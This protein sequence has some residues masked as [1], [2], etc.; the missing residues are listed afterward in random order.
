MHLLVILL[1]QLLGLLPG[2]KKA[3]Q[4][5]AVPV[6]RSNPRVPDSAARHDGN[7]SQFH[8]GSRMDW[9]TVPPFFNEVGVRP[10]NTGFSDLRIR[11]QSG[12]TPFGGSPPTDVPTD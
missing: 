9:M 7:V 8:W 1:Q 2:G 12:E 11:R 5:E 10:P 6:R 3:P 4:P